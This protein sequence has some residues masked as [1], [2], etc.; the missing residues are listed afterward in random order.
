M[1]SDLGGTQK[2]P[3]REL[4][5][6]RTPLGGRVDVLPMVLSHGEINMQLGLPAPIPSAWRPSCGSWAEGSEARQPGGR[7][8]GRRRRLLRRLGR[9]LF[10][11]LLGQRFLARGIELLQLVVEDALVE[12]LVPVV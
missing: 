11:Q 3:H 4:V 10:Q 6:G 12:G 5:E 1:R 9:G 8:A 2:E 7:L